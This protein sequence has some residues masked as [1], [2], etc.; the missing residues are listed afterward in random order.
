MRERSLLVGDIGGTKTKLAVATAPDGS[1]ARFESMMFPSAAYPGL[2]TIVREFLRDSRGEIGRAVLGVAG[3]VVEG[4]ASITKLPWQLDEQSLA[5]A[6]GIA[7]VKLLNDLEAVALALP[8]FRP[9]DVCTLSAGEPQRNAL[10]FPSE[11]F[12]YDP[13]G[14]E[15][16][17]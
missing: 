8:M 13:L 11:V 14:S 6:L 9:E 5:R 7:D 1:R 12:A 4:R 10:L 15:T 3:P 17:E 16:Q 2:E